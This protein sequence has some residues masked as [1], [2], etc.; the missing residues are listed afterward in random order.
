M[1]KPLPQANALEL[2]AFTF[3]VHCILEFQELEVILKI[4]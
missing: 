3:P 1:E 4:S 2:F